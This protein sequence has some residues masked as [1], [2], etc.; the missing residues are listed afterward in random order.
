MINNSELIDKIKSYNKFLNSDS[1]NKAYNFALDAHQDQKREQGVPY[2]I[3]PVAVANI[4]TDLKLDSATITTGLLHDT[5]EDTNV[6]YDTVKREFGEEVANLV[7]GV[8]KLS[9]L[10]NKAS[11]N[12][13]A[14][15]FRKL[16]LTLNDD[17]RVIIIKI[18]DRLHNMQTL[19]AMPDEKQIKIAS[20]TLYIYAPISHRIG[21]YNIKIELE[22][23]SF[24]YTES[25][26]YDTIKNKIEQSKEEQDLYIKSFSEI[27]QF[28]LA[29]EGL[30]YQ[31][32][33]RSKSIFSINRKMT[34]QNIPFENVFDKFAIRI[35]YKATHRNEK[36]LAWKIYSIMTS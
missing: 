5:I 3:H 25:N 26:S 30:K 27:I 23:L 33:G 4:L 24:K 36:F 2:I 22:D 34:M 15:N 8:T 16:L 20:E 13:K 7:D 17:I 6:T 9:A 1:L 29:E 19:D 10:E 28:A 35:I 32:K 31:I 21:L 18:A 12:S 14:E 11:A